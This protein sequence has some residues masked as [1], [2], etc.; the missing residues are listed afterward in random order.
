MGGVGYWYG[1]ERVVE[2]WGEREGGEGFEMEGGV[3]DGLDGWV[4]K[5]AKGEGVGVG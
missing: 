1:S 2:C 3:E 4:T 5:V